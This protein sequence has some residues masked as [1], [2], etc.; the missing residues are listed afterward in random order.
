MSIGQVGRTTC[1][2]VRRVK[3]RHGCE[4][5][6]LV[7]RKL[8]APRMRIW[9]VA[10][11]RN[12]YHTLFEYTLLPEIRIR[13]QERSIENC[14]YSWGVR[15]NRALHPPLYPIHYLCW[16]SCGMHVL[17]SLQ[18]SAQLELLNTR[19]APEMFTINKLQQQNVKITS[20]VVAK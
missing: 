19:H 15:S 12:V 7:D 3:E 16:H 14:T 17:D 20:G 5:D 6:S 10:I 8:D 2:N 4:V 18:L 13:S 1:S 11:W 9:S